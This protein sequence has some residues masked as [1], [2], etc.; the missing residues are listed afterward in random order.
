MSQDDSQGWRA[1]DSA[2]P[3]ESA[4]D[5]P[6]AVP[7][8]TPPPSPPTSPPPAPP[9]NG[10]GHGYGPPA[11][12]GPPPGYPPGGFA[13][14]G[15]YS[16]PY[17]RPPEPRPGIIALR[18]IGMSEIFNGAFGYI[19]RNPR[20]TLGLSV[21][22]MAAASA[23]ES[24]GVALFV[25][26]TVTMFQDALVDPTVLD[27]DPAPLSP[28]GTWS[29]VAGIALTLFTSMIL[30][31]LLT[32]IVSRAALG[33]STTL[34]AAWRAARGRLP[35]VIG[36]TLLVTLP[37]F[38]LT[39]AWA[40]FLALMTGLLGNVTG[41]LA[42]APVVVALVAVTAWIY[43]R[44]A[45]AVP[46]VVLE[47]LGP[48]VA[49]RRSWRLVAGSWWRC[50]GILLIAVIIVYVLQQL[51]TTPF[52]FGAGVI[53]WIGQGSAWAL[54]AST[55]V[56]FLGTLLLVAL[57]YPFLTGVNALLYL[58]L[59]MRREGLDLHLQT[60]HRSDEPL[61]ENALLPVPG[62][63][64]GSAAGSAANPGAPGATE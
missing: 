26:D 18:P 50:F 4:V 23:V 39:S 34:G 47:R 24:Y 33:N 60:L 8:G 27:Q 1:P 22:V 10:P 43:I 61:D 36:V 16:A 29:T 37:V 5:S 64:A 6:W 53:S 49:M 44:F 17:Q 57:T 54:P 48:L 58:D 41:G 20:A 63:E 2:R 42:A 15:N 56:L 13:A 25:D 7:G 19:R 55:G 59:R 35:A 51:L 9:A 14:P 38:V 30:T 3:S 46:A 40:G 11:P 12:G 32:L 28:G 21:I 45:L 31:G 52:I 62:P